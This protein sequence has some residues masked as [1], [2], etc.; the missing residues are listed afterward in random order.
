MKE[1]DKVHTL[2]K[3]TKVWKCSEG[4]FCKHASLQVWNKV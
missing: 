3:A 2:K 4:T 1:I